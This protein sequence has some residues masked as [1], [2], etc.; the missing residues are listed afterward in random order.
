MIQNA[1]LLCKRVLGPRIT[2]RRNSSLNQVVSSTK[3]AAPEVRGQEA[4]HHKIVTAATTT[5]KKKKTLAQVDEEM[6][7]AME[8]RAGE[9]GAH[10]AI[11]EGGKEVAMARA[12]KENMFRYI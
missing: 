3:K 6:R 1:R 2:V 8:D 9:G 12:V 11:I 10:G 5:K 4:S 7:R